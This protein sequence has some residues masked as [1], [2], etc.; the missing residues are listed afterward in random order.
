[1]FCISF[2][3]SWLTWNSLIAMILILLNSALPSKTLMASLQTLVN[4]RM[5]KSSLTFHSIVLRICLDTPQES[6][7]CSQSLEVRPAHKWFAKSVVLAKTVL[8]ISITCHLQSRTLSPS[9]PLFRCKL[10]EKK[11]MDMIVTPA[12]RRLTFQREYC[13][14]PPLTFWLCTF[15]VSSSTSILSEMT[16]STICLNSPLTST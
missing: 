16:R 8:K 4:R 10:M 14:L 3:N 2:K 9:T 6:I 12:R 15:N 13:C 7:S 5:H 11:S 1:M